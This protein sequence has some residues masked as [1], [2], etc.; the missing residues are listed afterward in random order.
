MKAFKSIPEPWAKVVAVL[1]SSAVGVLFAFLI[2]PGFG[3]GVAC[4]AVVCVL[5]HSA[6]RIDERPFWQRLFGRNAVY[7]ERQQD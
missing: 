5:I 4:G 3:A 2:E 1:G 7:G 6:A